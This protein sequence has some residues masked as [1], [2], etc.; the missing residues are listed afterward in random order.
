M[1]AHL[2]GNASLCS[3]LCEQAGFVNGAGEGL[4][5]ID[6]LACS[7]SLS[8]D[9]GVRVVG[10]ATD[11]GVCLVEQFGIHLLVVVVDLHVGEELLVLFE[12]ALCILLVHVAHAD[13]LN[14]VV[15]F[16]L[17]L[18]GDAVDVCMTAATHADGEELNLACLHVFLC[19]SFAEHVGGSH[20]KGSGC[21]CSC[22]EERS[23]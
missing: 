10:S 5:A 6:M 19:L 16:A 20:G 7:Q 9:D 8:T 2:S 14:V 18:V 13:E 3:K 21:C 22:L 11:D 4:F 15:D 12:H 23:S 17:S 1:V